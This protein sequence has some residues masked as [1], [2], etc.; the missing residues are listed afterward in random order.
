MLKGLTTIEFC[1]KQTSVASPQSGRFSKYDYGAYR[2]LKLGG[3]WRRSLSAH[4]LRKGLA[5]TSSK[6]LLKSPRTKTQEP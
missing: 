2:N 6:M 5:G 4:V 3:G 1:E